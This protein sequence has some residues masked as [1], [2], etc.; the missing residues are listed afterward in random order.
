MA[1]LLTEPSGKEVYAATA[2]GGQIIHLP[3]ALRPPAP[4][5]SLRLRRRL[6]IRQIVKLIRYLSHGDRQR[7]MGYLYRKIT[8]CAAHAYSHYLDVVTG[9][10]WMPSYSMKCGCVSI[11]RQKE[12][13]FPGGFSA[14]FVSSSDC[15]SP[16]QLNMICCLNFSGPFP[17]DSSGSMCS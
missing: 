3:L 11:T 15:L 9:N 2:F 8:E 13:G 14:L 7:A 1:A 5:I 17:K 12:M 4:L 10:C 6:Y 16:M